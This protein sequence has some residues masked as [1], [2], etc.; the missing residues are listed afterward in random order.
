MVSSIHSIFILRLSGFSR[1]LRKYWVDF[2][3]YKDKKDRVEYLHR[4]RV[5][6]NEV[7][8]FAFPIQLTE[9]SVAAV[10]QLQ[11]LNIEKLHREAA[12]KDVVLSTALLPRHRE[13]TVFIA[14]DL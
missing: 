8:N 10:G 5:A 3:F 1:V 11:T 14:V 4:L 12:D 6:A 9:T 13:G 7:F 2:N